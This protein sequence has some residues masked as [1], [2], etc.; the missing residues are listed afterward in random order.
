MFSAIYRNCRPDLPTQT[1]LGDERPVALDV[2]LL[3]IL[4]Q[5]APLANHLE[6]AP[7]RMVVVLVLAQVVRKMRYTPR[8]HGD[9]HLGRPC[10]AFVRPVLPYYLLFVLNYRQL[11]LSPLFLAIYL[12]LVNVICYHTYQIASFANRLASSTS[13][14]IWPFSS[15]TPE[16]LFSS[17]IFSRKLTSTSRP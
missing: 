14:E 5:P 17:R 4:E 3:Q 10:V 12:S 1:E 6:Q 15:S 11:L 16:N 8:E 7:P 2:L 9:L 13:R